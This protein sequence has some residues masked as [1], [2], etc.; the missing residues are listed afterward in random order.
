MT[1][2]PYSH[3]RRA[4]CSGGAPPRSKRLASMPIRYLVGTAQGK[5]ELRKREAHLTRTG[6]QRGGAESDGLWRAAVD[7][8][9]GRREAV[10]GKPRTRRAGSQGDRDRTSDPTTGSSFSTRP[11]RLGPSDTVRPDQVFPDGVLPDD[12]LSTNSGGEV[13]RH[14]L[15]HLCVGQRAEPGLEVVPHVRHARSRRDDA[16]HRR[17]RNDEFEKELRPAAAAE[18]GGV[19]G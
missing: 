7:E 18:L 4:A 3:R 13:L 15:S 5:L 19:G 8:P 9:E 2:I 17:M 1:P 6:R 10:A 11:P 14:A 16:G 12:V